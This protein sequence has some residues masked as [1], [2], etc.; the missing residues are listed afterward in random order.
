M[1]RWEAFVLAAEVEDAS[2]RFRVVRMR[3]GPPRGG[4][5]EVVVEDRE[6][7]RRLRLRSLQEWRDLRDRG[8]GLP[9]AV[10]RRTIDLLAQRVRWAIAGG[11]RLR[12][13]LVADYRRLSAAVGLRA[14][15]V[16]TWPDLEQGVAALVALA[17][18]AP[19]LPRA[20]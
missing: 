10:Q 9:T 16:S 4:G 12:G 6:E 1:R 11:G 20:V 5:H 19:A 3:L 14:L 18:R 8:L 15:P 7:R 17:R 2:P 13:D